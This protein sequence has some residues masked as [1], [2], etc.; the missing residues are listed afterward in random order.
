MCS[1]LKIPNNLTMTSSPPP[2]KLNSPTANQPN[3]HTT[4]PDLP[5]NPAL[6]SGS[7]GKHPYDSVL[8]GLQRKHRTSTAQK[9]DKAFSHGQYDEVKRLC[10]EL[11]SSAGNQNVSEAV[12]ARCWLYLARKEVTTRDDG[13][14]VMCADKAVRMWQMVLERRGVS[15]FPVEKAREEMKAA[16]RVVEEVK[17]ERRSPSL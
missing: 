16:Q 2:P 4:T 7:Y 9:I 15:R 10:N 3:Q 12:Q 13:F 6:I 14:R 8:C 5:A 11:L 1:L 17:R